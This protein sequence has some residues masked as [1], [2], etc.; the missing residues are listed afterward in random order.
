MNVTF[1]LGGEHHIDQNDRQ[2]QRLADFAERFRHHF[3]LADEFVRIAERHVQ[4]RNQFLHLGDQVADRHADGVRIHDNLALPVL[5]VDLGRPR[6]QRHIRH[7]A[8]PDERAGLGGDAHIGDVV[9]VPAPVLR[10]PHPDQIIL[11]AGGILVLGFQAK[12]GDLNDFAGRRRVH[13]D[14]ARPYRIELDDDLRFV[15]LAGKIDIGRAGNLFHLFRQCLHIAGQLHQIRSPQGDLQ[16]P[17]IAAAGHLGD[18]NADFQSGGVSHL[19]A[20]FIG[21]LGHGPPPF[22]A[23]NQFDPH[24]RL[25]GRCTARS[26]KQIGRIQ[27]RNRQHFF[28]HRRDQ[29]LHLVDGCSGRRGHRD[30]EL[31][32]I[33]SG[34][35]FEP[36]ERRQ[37]QVD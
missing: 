20:Q 4:T 35:E 15:L 9:D 21:D 16:R 36:D 12:E 37:H 10:H 17:D 23:G 5:A 19:G 25:V 13:A 3:R 27:F 34:L 1:K 2:P 26:Q 7:V 29:F 14:L 24:A 11:I 28:F 6:R 32:G 22:G 30:A 8:Q 33:I 31:A 18:L